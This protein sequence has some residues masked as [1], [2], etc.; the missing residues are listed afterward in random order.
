MGEPGAERRHQHAEWHHPRE[1][2]QI[3]KPEAR[4]WQIGQPPAVV[5][6]AERAA[7]GN[8]EANG[9]RSADGVLSADIAPGQEWNGKGASADGD[10]RRQG[11]DS[12]SHSKYTA[13]AGQLV[14]RAEVAAGRA[15][16]QCGDQ[17]F[18]ADLTPEGAFGWTAAMAGDLQP[19]LQSSMP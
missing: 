6:V 18:T 5:D 2:W 9:C 8:R 7:K 19:P 3:N 12:R 10:Q 14:H 16:L 1:R 15:R 4:C 11:A 13:C 17:V